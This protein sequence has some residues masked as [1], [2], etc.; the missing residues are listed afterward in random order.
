MS[1]EN[2]NLPLTVLALCIITLA[3]GSL[4]AGFYVNPATGEVL[5]PEGKPAFLAIIVVFLYGL[6]GYLKSMKPEDF[7]PTKFVITLVISLFT[8]LAMFELGVGYEEASH[9]VTNLF[10][11]T[12]ATVLIENWLKVFIRQIGKT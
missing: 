9:I 2:P 12:G 11:T 8:T 1:K 5:L 4:I 7:D 10:V 3:V 6:S